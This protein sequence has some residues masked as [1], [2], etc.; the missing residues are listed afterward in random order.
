M[1]AVLIVIVLFLLTL[2]ALGVVATVKTVRA[3]RRGVERTGAQA[4]R[5]VTETTLRAK[6]AQPGAFG[7]LASMR[8]SLRQS[9]I[10]TREALEGSV[11][12]DPSLKEALGLLERLREH[13]HALD[14]ELRALEREP[15]RARVGA[16]LPELR[17][18][19]ERVTHSADSLRWAAQDRARQ[20]AD[21]ELAALGRQIELEAGA[22]RHWVPAEGTRALNAEGPDARR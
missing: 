3:V 19:T 18:R 17:E 22:L 5:V 7:E 10:G 9:I 13:A 8:L 14:D 11:A 4:R 2:F 1:E 16:R 21:D 20:F 12:D 15:D 6:R